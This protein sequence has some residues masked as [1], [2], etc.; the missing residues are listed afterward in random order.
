MKKPVGELTAED[1]A[2]CPIWTYCGAADSHAVV[3]PQPRAAISETDS[4]VFL[5]ATDFLFAD[6]TSAAG[7]CSPA[8]S[9]GLD[10]LQPVVFGPA[11]P[12]PLWRP[13]IGDAAPS[14][15]GRDLGRTV[16]EVFPLAWRA[17]VAVDGERRAG[18]ITVADVGAA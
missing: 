18:Q 12:V 17:S 4:S 10:Y 14:Q 7:Y 8:D 3:E 16:G 2:A 1:F 9:S 5:A 11:G 6:G 15:I 13:G